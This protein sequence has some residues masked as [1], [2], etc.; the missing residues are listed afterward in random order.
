MGYEYQILD[1]KIEF[2]SERALQ[3]FKND[4][5]KHLIDYDCPLIENIGEM[6]GLEITQLNSSLAKWS[7]AKDASWIQLLAKYIRGHIS[8]SGDD[9]LDFVKI[10]FDGQGGFN[11][12]IGEIVWRKGNENDDKFW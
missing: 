5:K 12:Y 7:C 8:L 10:V 2:I 4:E 1:F 6:D 3:N 11:Y 9:A